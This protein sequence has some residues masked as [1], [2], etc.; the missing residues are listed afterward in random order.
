MLQRMMLQVGVE[1]IMQITGKHS[2]DLQE[3][4]TPLDVKNIL[5]LK[6]WLFLAL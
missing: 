6:G 2:K 4:Q 5:V 3:F 1:T